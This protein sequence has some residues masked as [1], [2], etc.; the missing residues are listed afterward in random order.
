MYD[1]AIFISVNAV[2]HALDFISARREWP[3]K[4][5]IATI[6]AST[7]LALARYGLAADL[8]PHT[9]FNSEALLALDELRNLHARRVVIFRG[10]GGRE[11]LYDTLVARG[12]EV[13][14][15][16]VY[17]RACPVIDP[18]EIMPYWE[19]GILDV[20]TITSNESLQNLYDMAGVAGQPM[21]CE[22]PL[23]VAGPRQRELAQRLGFRQIPVMA[24]NATDE[25]MV[26][27]LKA[28]PRSGIRGQC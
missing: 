6:G 25:A 11:L 18:Q 7:A 8:V 12:A 28:F 23:L 1:F 10:A 2:T 21:L 3:R 14:Y 22:L 19:P 13:D 17:R 4:V 16:E 9:Q 24:A 15:V 27:A 5:R 26:T 20:I